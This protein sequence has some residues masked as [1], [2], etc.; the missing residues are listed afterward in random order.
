[1]SYWQA[2][3]RIMEN[4]YLIRTLTNKYGT[5][6]DVLD[7][8]L[9]QSTS[10]MAVGMTEDEIRTVQR[11]YAMGRLDIDTLKTIEA[12]ERSEVRAGAT[13]QRGRID[14]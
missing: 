3:N 2:I 6:V 10:F 14:G 13:G 7:S 9:Q 11:A 4:A 5:T 12:V 8:I 1:M